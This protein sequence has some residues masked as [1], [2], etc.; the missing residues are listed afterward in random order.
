MT[1]NDLLQPLL[2]AL[3]MIESARPLSLAQVQAIYDRTDWS[4]VADDVERQG[5]CIGRH[6]PISMYKAHALP[7][8]VLVRSEA[9][10]AEKIAESS[11]YRVVCGFRGQPPTRAMLWHF[12]NAPLPGDRAWRKKFKIY[13]DPERKV[14][15]YRILQKLLLSIWMT[16]RRID[17]LPPY[18][19][20]AAMV[21]DIAETQE[22][23]QTIAI[24]L[25]SLPG[26]EFA[27][28]QVLHTFFPA[29]VV[30]SKSGQPVTSWSMHLPPWWHD[31]QALQ[32]GRA[33]TE[34]R[35]P[36]QQ[37]T[38][39]SAI[40]KSSDDRILLGKRKGGYKSDYFALP[41][42]V[43]RGGESLLQ[44]I[45]R[46]VLEETGLNI[47][48]MRP[49]STS[50]NRDEDSGERCWSIGWL[51]TEFQGNPYIR[52]PDRCESWD[53]YEL[54]D[55]PRPL[56]LPSEIIIEDYKQRRFPRLSPEELEHRLQ[57]MQRIDDKPILAQQLCLPM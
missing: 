51:V 30:I 45:E 12:R 8:L 7:Y 41:G 25:P 42:G 39:C 43:L 53:W 35:S 18:V 36:F 15:F 26:V 16:A 3:E 49:V 14:W 52:E 6:D 13:V 38:A 23:L 5:R 47:V 2:P 31:E 55:L 32:G 11:Q 54:D 27:L 22:E 57:E 56:F 20:N 10:L 37:Y 29:Q 1:K 46:E 24:E 48:A 33:E 19:Y 9:E 17:I 40:I 4:F 44:C 34:S 21:A 50:F 28:T